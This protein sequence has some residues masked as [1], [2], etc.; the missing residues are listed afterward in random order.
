MATPTATSTATAT[1]CT[2]SFSD[3]QPAD[4]FYEPVRYLYC[5]GVVSGYE[6]GTFKPYNQ[7]TRSQMA[8]IVVLAE[9]WSLANPDNPSFADVPYGSTFYLYIETAYAHSILGGYPC[10]GPGEPCDMPDPPISV[11]TPR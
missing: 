4:Y 10:G 9:V 8:K 6:D 5:R 11:P 3:V 2:I 1:P 7:T